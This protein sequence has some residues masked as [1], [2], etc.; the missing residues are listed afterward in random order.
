[1]IQF[2]E[3]TATARRICTNVE[4][5]L[6]GKEDAIQRAIETLLAGGHLL[7]EDV[8]GVGKTTL[9]NALSHS[10][11]G[12]FQRIQFTSDLL[13]SD[14]L[15]AS[16]PD[17]ENGHPTGGFRFQPGPIFASV[18]LADE[19]NRANPKTQSALLE[20]MS[21][22]AVTIDGVTHELPIPF[23][24]IATQNPS[25]QYGTHPLPESQLDRFMTRIQL[26]YPD[27]TSEL[28]VLRNDPSRTQLPNLK[29]VADLEDLRGIQECVEEIKI[30][31][32]IL[33]YL[34]TIVEHTRQHDAISLGVSTRGA[35]AL[36][37]AA[38][39][40]ALMDDRDYCVPDDVRD[41]AISVFAHRIITNQ[42][43]GLTQGSEEATWVL[44][45]I[46]DQVPIPL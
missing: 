1:L 6:H 37:R 11:D 25:D 21:E 13:P 40:H 29:A 35:L 2:S 26:G 30:N 24:V 31:D 33:S 9:A 42:G 43:G 46:L 20:A 10:I 18:V 45:E 12:A 5:A 22:G 3:A 41:I 39:A 28:A 34:L 23:F 36:R 7:L 16:M 19:I 27:T 8:P 32:S 4:L 14:I 38:Q 15:G 17:Y 44:R